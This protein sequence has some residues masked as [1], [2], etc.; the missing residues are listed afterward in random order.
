[1]DHIIFYYRM[2]SAVL[3]KNSRIIV[4]LSLVSEVVRTRNN[5]RVAQFPNLA[6][7]P[8]VTCITLT[9]SFR[10]SPINREITSANHHSPS[11]SNFDHM[12]LVNLDEIM[13]HQN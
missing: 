6:L 8:T 3:L 12:R 11:S 10:S 5:R 2:D 9:T 13:M 7:S 4:D 1:M